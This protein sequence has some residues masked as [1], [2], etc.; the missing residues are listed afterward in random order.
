MR[1]Q[2]QFKTPALI[3]DA[4]DM[5]ARELGTRGPHP[6]SIGKVTYSVPAQI[7]NGARQDLAEPLELVTVRNPSGY[8]VFFDTVRLADGSIRSFSFAAE[9]YV[10]RFET[11]ETH[12]YQ[13]GEQ[14]ALALP[15]ARGA[16]L[17]VDLLPGYVYPYPAT[18]TFPAGRGPALIR[19]TL[20]D[21]SGRGIPDVRIALTPTPR[22]RVSSDPTVTRPWRFGEYVTDD[23]GQ[24]SLVVPLRGDY[25]SPQPRLPA[26]PTVTVRFTFP[27][28]PV[29]DL[30]NIRFGSG[31]ETSLRQAALRGTVARAAGGPIAG[32]TIDVSGEPDTTRSASDGS[33]VHYF[34]L[35]QANAVVTVTATLP[36][37]SN[38]AQMNIPVRARQ[39]VW[40]PAFRF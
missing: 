35:T 38:Q 3:L 17:H 5:Y 34:G 14:T 22:I 26:G 18:G 19:G 2:A 11:P 27:H 25:P 30:P 40:V 28:G 13:R 16:S 4:E 32:A 33:W 12:V 8:D 23:S 39:T 37:G 1:Y 31:E 6:R 9:T 7:V 29:T 24:W 21:A 10:L 15:A 36:D 20:F